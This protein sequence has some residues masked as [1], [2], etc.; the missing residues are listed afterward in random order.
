MRNLRSLSDSRICGRRAALV[1]AIATVLAGS[2]AV[3]F[4]AGSD[5]DVAIIVNKANKIET[6][7]AKDLK[8]IFA[9]EKT[10]W[11]DGGKIQT[12]ATSAAMPEHKT[13]IRFL[14]GMSEPDY[15]KYCIHASFVGEAQ[16]VPRESGT[17]PVVQGLVAV[18]PGAVGFVRASQVSPA[19]KVLKIDGMA[20]GDPG[21]PLSG[22][23]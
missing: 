5:S 6:I 1:T 10:R 22:E 17:S 18:I 13:A 3:T 11:P 8:Q 9:G 2:A 23:K 21:Y 7:S 19:V 16:K 12:L 14:F 4:A 20:P 15:Q